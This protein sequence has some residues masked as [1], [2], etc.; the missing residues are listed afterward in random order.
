MT[1]TD[2][3]GCAVT[4]EGDEVAVIDDAVTDYLTMA[5]G[6]ERHLPALADGGPLAKT[7]LAQFYLQAHRRH[8]AGRARELI[9]AA[10]TE[11]ATIGVSDRER[12]V[13]GAVGSSVDGRL[14]DAIDR[15]DQL[16]R[17][18]PTDA[19]ALRAQHHLL[20]SSG[21]TGE[22][23]DLVRRVRPAWSEDLPL[24]SLLDGQEAFGLEES[25]RYAEA[26]AMGRRGVERDPSDLWAIHAVAHVFQ[27]QQRWDEGARWLDGREEVLDA[28][29]G[30]AGHLWWHQSLP[31]L[32]LG[33]HDDVL[34]LF[35]ERIHKPGSEEGLDLS[36]A[37]SLLARLEIAGVDVGDRWAPLAEPCGARRGQHSHPFND[38]HYALAMAKAGHD[39]ALDTHLAGMAAWSGGDDGAA[40]VI[41]VVGL[42]TAR[43]LA[44]WG[45]G[46]WR[47]AVD[48][49]GPVADETWRLGG[50]HA[51]RDVYTQIRGHAARM[52]A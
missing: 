50:S 11:A 9:E 1:T 15:F 31:L 46:R 16:L 5:P 39:D 26:E 33:R 49:L 35:D 2:R 38:T 19:F 44:A 29:G 41:R 17:D 10:T 30:F 28:G 52:A 37:V 45:R 32:A 24:T 4:A 36:N 20:F 22:M 8:L 48:E 13:L 21:R 12:A 23:V 14:R 40:E 43:G 18:H 3:W 47:E 25:G 42:A 7:I 34:T 6:L 27:M 51:Q